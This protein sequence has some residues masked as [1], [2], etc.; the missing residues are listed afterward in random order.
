MMMMMPMQQNKGPKKPGEAFEHEWESLEVVHHDWA[1]D[2]QD[3]RD[4][5]T[6]TPNA[7]AAVEIGL[8]KKW[9]KQA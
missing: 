2:P 1:L 7:L 4:E 3:N 8:L 5:P 6:I 9:E